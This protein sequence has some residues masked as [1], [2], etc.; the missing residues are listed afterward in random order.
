M[1]TFICKIQLT[2]QGMKNIKASCERAE[3]FRSAAANMGV[4]V[5][6]IYWTMGS[7]DGVVIFDAPDSETATA[8]MMH[9]GSGGNVHTETARAYEADEISGILAKL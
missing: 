8:A 6:N 7:F 4:Q 1:A 3:G 9:L 5:K 2:D